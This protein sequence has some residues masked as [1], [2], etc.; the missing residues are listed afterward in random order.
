MLVNLT[1]VFVNEGKV[2]NISVEYEPN[3][4]V[5]QLGQFVIKQKNPIE[6]KLSN[7]GRSKALVEGKANLTFAFTCDRC[8]RDVDYTFD[9]SFEI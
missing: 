2:Q 6:L 9:L 3:E 8:L 7:I 5:S 4:F 1:D